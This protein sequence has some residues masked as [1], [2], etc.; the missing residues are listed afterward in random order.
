MSIKS[1]IAG[2]IIG[3]AS[4]ALLA[5]ATPSAAAVVQ[6]NTQGAFNAAATGVTTFGFTNLSGINP[7]FDVES[8]PYTQNG[9]T[10]TND[11]TAADLDTGGSPI[12]FVIN[13]GATPTYGV[14]FLSFQNTQT[15]MTGSLTSAGFTAFGFTFG[16]YLP[17]GPATLTLNTGE[18]FQIN[19]T[20]TAQFIGFISDAP[21]TSASFNYAGSYAFDI[22]NVSTGSG[23][24][25]EPATWAMMLMGFG[26]AGSALRRRQTYR[27]VEVAADGTT[28]SETFRAEDDKSA[29]AQA[30]GVAEGSVIEIW[31]GDALV[32][33]CDLAGLAAA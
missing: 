10:F 23:A 32:T 5:I 4:A 3:V 25:P 2:V 13:A 18:S 11:V 6:Y 22:L 26:L 15:G 12:I 17:V 20:D 9:V 21:I 24:V 28:S 7:G 27:L 30:L 19:P 31:R 1:G 16:S 8:N 29:L 14:D 33:R